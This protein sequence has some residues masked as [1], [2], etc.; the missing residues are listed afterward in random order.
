MILHTVNKSPFQQNVLAQCLDRCDSNDGIILLE[1][2]VYGVLQ[3][4][5]QADQLSAVTCFA[6]E[7]DM[8]AR[9]LLEKSLIEKVQLID[10]HR[11]VNLSCDYSLVLSWY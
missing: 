8:E 4:N 2:G 7:A 6:I 1:D 5:P 10:F 11:F 3:D 9:G